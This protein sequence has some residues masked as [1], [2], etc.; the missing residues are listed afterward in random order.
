MKIYNT[1]TN[2]IQEFIP[3]KENEVKMYV[4]GPTVYNYIHIGNTRPIIVFDVLARLLSYKGYKVTYVQNFTDIDDKIIK[5]ANE[6]KSSCQEITKKY[7]KAFMEDTSKLNLYP[8]I[9]RPTVTENLD[10]IKNLIQKL[11]D[12]GYAYKKDNDIVF[13]IDQFKDYGKLSKQKL[14]ELNQGVRIEVDENKKNPFDFVLWKGK[15]EN[16]PYFK[17]SFGEGR[18]GWHIECSALIHKYL[19]DRIDIHAGGQDLIFPHHEN[20]RA[21]SICGITGDAEFVN[22]WMH[23]SYITINSEKMSKSLGNFMLLKDVLEKYEGYV[24][25]HFILTCHYRKN[26]N[27]SYSDL[28]ISKKTLDRL[29][30]TM[31]K[32]KSHNKGVK[33][34]VL[35]DLIKEFKSNFIS[36]LEDDL[37]TPKA[38]SYISIFTK[39]VNK[40]LNDDVNVEEAY[41]A[42]VEMLD[43]LGINLPIKKEDDNDIVNNLITLLK[44]VRNE[45]RNQKIYNLSDKIREELAKLGIN[46]SDK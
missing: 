9:I 1:L 38:L 13:S 41:N 3:L 20:E 5:K 31:E 15:K 4:C 29:T 17:S 35:D 12:K 11:I 34:E 28:D 10:E 44:D 40:L 2:S 16:E 8:G 14:D 26:L 32:F 27:F 33:P 36:S 25:R 18:P 37:N 19:G 45:L 21:Q 6:E 7:I 43:I 23:N 30:T 42:L 39:S 46:I 22:Y 24:I